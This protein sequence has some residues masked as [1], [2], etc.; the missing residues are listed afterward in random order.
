MPWNLL[1]TYKDPF[2]KTPYTEEW[3]FGVKQQIDEK[4]A[5]SVDYVGSHGS[6]LDL[7]TF[8][9]TAVTPAPGPLAAANHSLTLPRPITSAPTDA[10]VTKRYLEV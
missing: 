6:R 8:F 9:N 10:A 4:T 2:M 5:L 3:N 1:Q 7:N